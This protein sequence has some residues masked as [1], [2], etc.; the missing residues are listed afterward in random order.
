[1]LELESLFI[2]YTHTH[3]HIY[4]YVHTV[5]RHKW[6]KSSRNLRLEVYANSCIYD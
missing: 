1:M 6:I 5:T 3:T 2:L 4:I